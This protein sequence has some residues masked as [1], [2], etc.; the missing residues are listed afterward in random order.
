MKKLLKLR[1]K[2]TLKQICI[3]SILIPIILFAIFVTSKQPLLKDENI[4]LIIILLLCSAASFG[5][6]TFIFLGGLEKTF[7]NEKENSDVEKYILTLFSEI[8]VFYEFKWIPYEYNDVTEMVLTLIKNED[9][10]FYAKLL[11][12]G[13]IQIIAKGMYDKIIYDK[14]CENY[15]YFKTNFKLITNNSQ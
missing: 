4:I 8:D 12:T 6:L 9:I 10:K 1:N 2:L 15:R 14:T 7:F 11:E 5:S 3:V 13:K